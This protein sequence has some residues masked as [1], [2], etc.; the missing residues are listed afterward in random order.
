MNNATTT[1]RAAVALAVTAALMIVGLMGAVGIIGVEG[2]PADLMYFGVL[3]VGIGGT[4]GAGLHP[5]GMARALVA[6]ATAQALVAVIALLMGKHLSPVT[7][8]PELVGLNGMFVVLFLASAAL[9]RRA[10]QGRTPVGAAA[11]G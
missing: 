2:D 5:R 9:F 1:Y 11:K 7:S 3:C 10:A 8:V 4:A 6:T